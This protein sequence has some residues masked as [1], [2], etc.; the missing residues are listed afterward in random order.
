MSQA[1][2]AL[3]LINF[4]A[5]EIVLTNGGAFECR[6]STQA[7]ESDLSL[8]IDIYDM[9]N[10]VH[11]DGHLGWWQFPVNTLDNLMHGTLTEAQGIVH[12]TLAGN[13]PTHHWIN[14]R[15]VT[16]DRLVVNAVLRANITN[17]IVHLDKVPL[18]KK[19]KDLIDF[20]AGFSRDWVNPRFSSPGFVFPPTST[21]CI[22]ARN[23]SPR[24]AVGN[25]C[26]DVFRMLKQNN[27]PVEMYAE[28]TDLVINDIVLKIERLGVDASSD[29]QLLYFFSTYDPNLDRLLALT[30]SRRIAY[31]HGVTKPALLQVFDPELSMSCEKAYGQMRCLQEFDF[32]AANS[33]VSALALI[34]GFDEDLDW[35]TADI[36]TIPPRLLSAGSTQQENMMAKKQRTKLLYVGRIKSHKKIEHCLELYSA[37][38]K[39][40]T[41]TELWIVGGG[42]DKAYWDYLKWIETSQLKIPEGKIHWVG[43]ISDFELAEHYASASAYI[44]MSEDEGFCLP[45]LEAMLAGLPVFTYGLPAI[46]EVMQDSGIYFL[47]KDYEHLA[48]VLH[49]LLTDSERMREVIFKQLER[50]NYLAREMDGRG[51]FGLLEPIKTIGDKQ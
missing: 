25:L 38:L 9:D 2:G 14:E 22:V 34:S 28:N 19:M 40:D 26:L 10:P 15:K 31:F 12:C 23:I 42:A 30:F 39:L 49:A 20:R 6:L 51:F 36:R 41:E 46:R 17:A 37:Y 3:S 50:A 27:I 33:K 5:P 11:P 16:F 21:V 7:L 1:T 35:T 4:I 44:S 13:E 43:S 47:Q 45:I 32:I 18:F 8:I 24:D 29:N 48:G